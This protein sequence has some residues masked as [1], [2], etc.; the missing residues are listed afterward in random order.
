VAI[1]AYLHD[2]RSDFSF[3]AGCVNFS[4]LPSTVRARREE[5]ILSVSPDVATP[6]KTALN[7]VHRQMGAK[8]VDFNGWDMPVNIPSTAD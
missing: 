3:P 1:P 8:M 5:P 4:S 7:A 2:P 6:R